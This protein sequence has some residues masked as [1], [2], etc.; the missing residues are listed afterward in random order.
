MKV[1]IYERYR[2]TEYIFVNES[3]TAISIFNVK[4]LHVYVDS[5]K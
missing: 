4:T 3:V 2:E 5:Q 1:Y